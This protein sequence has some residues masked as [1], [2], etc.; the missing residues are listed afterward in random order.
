M[1]QPGKLINMLGGVLKNLAAVLSNLFLIILTMIFMLLEAATL[2]LKLRAAVRQER[3]QHRQL[4]VRS[5]PRS[6]IIS[7]SRPRPA[8]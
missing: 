2:P 6:S 3:L 1:L 7:A 5:R 4:S 8:S